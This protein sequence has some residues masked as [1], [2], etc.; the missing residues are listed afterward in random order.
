M[1][2]GGLYERNKFRKHREIIRNHAACP[3]YGHGLRRTVIDDC[4]ADLDSTLHDC[5]INKFFP[6]VQR[7]SRPRNSWKPRDLCGDVCRISVPR[8]EGGQLRQG[9][10]GAVGGGFVVQGTCSWRTRSWYC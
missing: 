4:R 7:C 2:N 6:S 3:L 8:F 10:S 1:D 9:W 5:L